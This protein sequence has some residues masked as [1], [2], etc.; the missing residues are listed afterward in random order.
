M[1]CNN[2]PCTFIHR[3]FPAVHP[4]FKVI[5]VNMP[6]GMEIGSSLKTV[7]AVEFHRVGMCEERHSKVCSKFL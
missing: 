5:A 7:L 2:V 6:A 1:I 4:H 3:M